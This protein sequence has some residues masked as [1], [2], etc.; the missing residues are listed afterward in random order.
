VYYSCMRAVSIIL[1]TAIVSLLTACAPQPTE[2]AA[3]PTT[4]HEGLQEV[5]SRYFDVAFARPGVDFGGYSE[6]LVHAPELAFRTPDRSQQQFP[7]TEEQK[8]SFRDLLESRFLAE[9]AN[10]KKLRVTDRP[11]PGVLD[12]HIG[13]QDIL[14][15]VP[16]RT[17]GRAGRGGLALQ[18]VGEATFIIELRDAES[19]EV[20]ARVFD[21]RAIEGV[22]MAQGDTPI[23]RWEDVETI[24]KSW[25]ATV[26]ARLDA[27]VSGNY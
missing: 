10:L 3:A 16:P 27:I 24:C 26:R 6:L 19:A 17:V 22:A 23:T 4:N 8:A 11:G 20:L 21:N 12:L 25:A 9:F 14:A 15:T 7:L 13:V 18:A 2:R 1:A 5:P